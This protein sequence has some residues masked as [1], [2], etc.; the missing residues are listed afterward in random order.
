MRLFSAVK[1]RTCGRE[2]ERAA[3]GGGGDL[4]EVSCTMNKKIKEPEQDRG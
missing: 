2:R 1:E 3:H 4:K